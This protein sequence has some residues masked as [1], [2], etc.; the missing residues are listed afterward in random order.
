MRYILRL[1]DTPEGMSAPMVLH[2]PPWARAFEVF[3]SMLGTPGRNESDPSQLLAVIASSIFGF[4]FGD[5]GQGAVVLIAGLVLGRRIPMT[6]MLVPG[7]V[8]AMVFGALFGS[9]FGLEHVIPALW[10]HP[11]DE[12]ITLLIVAVIAGM[13]IIA[14][15]L[16]LDAI[17]MHWRGKRCIGGRIAPA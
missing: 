16:V 15:G 10:M 7:G 3:A 14:L 5:V 1:A 6:R 2:N 9:V 13:A 11:M 12:P 17:Q 8:M 4:M